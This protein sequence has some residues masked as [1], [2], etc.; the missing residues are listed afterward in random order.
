MQFGFIAFI[1]LC[2]LFVI[3]YEGQKDSPGFLALPRSP[4][5]YI[6]IL[7]HG[8]EV[9]VVSWFFAGPIIVGMHGGHVAALA[10]VGLCMLLAVTAAVTNSVDT[11]FAPTAYRIAA[12]FGLISLPFM[13]LMT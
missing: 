3:L 5:D 1:Y 11:R 7:I 10:S 6:R 9:L 8:M 13:F 12:I 4:I 2:L